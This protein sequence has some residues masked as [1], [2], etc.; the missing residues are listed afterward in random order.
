MS[1]ITSLH[2]APDVQHKRHLPAFWRHFL[3]MLAAMMV[4][5]IATARREFTM[6]TW[7]SCGVRAGRRAGLR[8]GVVLAGAAILAGGMLASTASAATVPRPTPGLV[9][10]ASTLVTSS[11]DSIRIFY[12]QASGSL[13]TV[14]GPAASEWG[15]PQN[16][17]GVLTSGPAA[18]TINGG[19]EEFANTWVFARGTDNAVWYREFVGARGSWGPWTRLGGKRALGAPGVT[20]LGGRASSPIVFI[21]GTNGALWQRSLSGG[22]WVSRGG[23]LA[24]P[25]APLPAVAGKC[26]GRLD[27]FA[28]GTDHKVRE[29]TG[30]WHRVG[31]KAASAPAAVRLPSGETDLFI[32]GT[33]NALWMNVRV[34]GA[35]TWQGWHRIGGFLTSAP[36]ATIWPSSFLG[37]VRTVLF[38]GRNG[39]LRITQNAVGTSTWT[40]G[41]VP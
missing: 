18:I 5:M 6:F 10:G 37:Q 21:R 22:G 15:M 1:H 33:D 38:L 17:G 24:S 35:L 8:G 2:H 36:T 3:Q 39:N 13:I 23:H 30:T 32:R 4:G 28:L 31:G 25:P 34:P 11:E 20:C 29:F 14:F 16:L 7:V 40:R 12:Q 41:Q 19:F 9:P 27:V 26:P